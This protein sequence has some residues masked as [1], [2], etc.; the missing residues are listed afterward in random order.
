MRVKFYK[1]KQKKFMDEFIKKMNSPSLRGI[2][3]VWVQY[4]LFHAKELS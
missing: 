1:G 3:S 2:S 4:P